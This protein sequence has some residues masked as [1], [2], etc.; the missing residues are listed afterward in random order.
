[1]R[2]IGAVLLILVVFLASC[3]NPNAP[4]YD[5]VLSIEDSVVARRSPD[6]VTFAVAVRVSNH[7]SR[8]VFYDQQC[9]HAL[10][11][12]E[13]TGWRTVFSPVC[14]PSQYSMGIFP[15]ESRL[16]DIRTR[17]AVTSATWP[18]VGAA[19]EYRVVLWLTSVPNN[20]YGFSPNPLGPRSRTSPTF[21]ATEVVIVF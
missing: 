10:Q 2:S 16:F 12:R 11:R 9:G 7:D 17:A 15:G 5:L 6:E 14:R 18:A 4:E 19:G 21:S 1:M 3:G 20:S 13:G 8:T